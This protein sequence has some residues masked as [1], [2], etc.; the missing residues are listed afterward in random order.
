MAVAA[1]R[2]AD[3]TNAV[4]WLHED[5]SRKMWHNLWPQVPAN[6]VPIGHVTNGVHIRSWMSQEIM[7]VVDRY[8]PGKWM[9]DPADHSVWEGV[10]QIPDEELWRAH[11]RSRQ[12]LVGYVRHQFKDQL[13]RA[14]R[15]V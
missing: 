14:R 3:S 10:T 11:E 5:V 6:E 15:V 7:Y 9:T 2:L 13:S 12:R 8:L 1:I 4:S